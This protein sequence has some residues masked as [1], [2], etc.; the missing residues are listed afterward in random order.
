MECNFVH[1]A[2][3]DGYVN[4]CCRALDKY[5]REVLFGKIQKYLYIFKGKIISYRGNPNCLN[6]LRRKVFKFL[7]YKI[8]TYL[9]HNVLTRVNTTFSI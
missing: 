6:Q 4:R 1:G 8:F 7:S 3:L 5:P 9:S 2:C